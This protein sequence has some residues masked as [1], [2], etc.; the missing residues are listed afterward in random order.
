MLRLPL[1]LV[2]HWLIPGQW[3]GVAMGSHFCDDFLVRY[4]HAL[5]IDVDDPEIVIDV[6]AGQSADKKTERH[7]EKL[8]A[9]F[10]RHRLARRLGA[11][12]FDST[13]AG[14]FG[15]G[16]ARSGNNRQH[17]SNAASNMRSNNA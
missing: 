16:G 12:R 11:L 9:G 15:R 13:S 4:F 14:G 3:A 6:G 10:A 17:D 1:G 7:I 5:G 2:S 8:I